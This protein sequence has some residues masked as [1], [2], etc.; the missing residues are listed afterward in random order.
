MAQRNFG[1][2][3]AI[4]KKRITSLLVHVRLLSSVVGLDDLWPR[5]ARPWV[6]M[7]IVLKRNAH[8]QASRS[9][10]LVVHA[11]ADRIN[12]KLAFVDSTKD[13]VGRDEIEGLVA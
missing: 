13:A 10:E 7:H 6:R 12:S 4:L 9:V 5:Q 3:M 8:S 2:G 1:E 11:D